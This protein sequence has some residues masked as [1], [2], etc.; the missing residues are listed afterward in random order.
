MMFTRICFALH[1]PNL[2]QIERRR[3]CSV[4]STNCA[5]VSM[6]IRSEICMYNTGVER[7]AY[8]K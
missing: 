5:I 7:C 2:S 4:W 3:L 1:A 8:F 6:A